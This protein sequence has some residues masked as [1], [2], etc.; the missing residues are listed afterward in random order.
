VNRALR[1]AAIGVLLIAPVTLSACSSGQVNQTS[2]QN[3][4]KV[5]A[6]ARVGSITVRGAEL[7]FPRGGSY[8]KGSDA[9]LDAAIINGSFSADTL[10]SITG[11]GFTGV[12]VT[13]TGAQATFATGGA[14]AA[15]TGT[16][17][18][19][20]GGAAATTGATATTGAAATGAAG[21]TTTGA[22]VPTAVPLPSEAPSSEVGIQI[23]AKSV[24]YLG[25]NAPHISLTGLTQSLNA[26]QSLRVTFT[27]QRAGAVTLDVI[28]AN[29]SSPVPN[30]STFD[31]RVP[32]QGDVPSNRESGGIPPAAN[33]DSNG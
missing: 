19:A 26:A 11:D 27:F 10:V 7:A 17:T 9:V 30:S 25:Q 2:S 13:G 24:V 15:A 4:D 22:T 3:R 12:D 32:T 18:G 21:A 31:F 5:G 23:P 6:T 33:S 1:A 28:V 14:A 29:P 8:P 16:G 20:T